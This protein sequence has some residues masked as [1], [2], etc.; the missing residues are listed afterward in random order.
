MDKA[1]VNVKQNSR[2]VQSI[3]RKSIYEH[4]KTSENF[5]KS[6]IYQEVVQNKSRCLCTNESLV[7]GAGVKTVTTRVS[8][9]LLFFLK[10]ST[11]YS[12]IEELDFSKNP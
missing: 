2:V 10:K 4:I 5:P 9:L 8:I 7:T 6:S 11:R 1:S 3:V 12:N